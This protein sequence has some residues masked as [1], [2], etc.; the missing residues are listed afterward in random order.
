MSE[1]REL[2][3]SSIESILDNFGENYWRKL[4]EDGKYPEEFVEEFERKGFSSLLIPKEY[5]GLG[6]G[7]GEASI[8]L[9]EINAYGGNS[10]PFHGLY[11][12][13]FLVS[14]FASRE[15]KENYLPEIAKGKKRLQSFALTEPEAGSD[16]T[17]IKTFAKREG[18]NYVI[19]G[20][21]IFISRLEQTDL[22]VL[23]ART[24]PYEKVE[25]KTDGITLFLID[26][27]KSKGIKFNRI[28]TMFN[29]QTYE[30]FIED[31][32][33]GKESVIGDEGKGF[34]YLLYVL[35]PERILIAS[36]CIGDARWFINKAAEYSKNRI[37]FGR[38]I[39]SNQGIQFPVADA[40]ARLVASDSVRWKA[41]EIFERVEKG[42]GEMKEL[43]KYSNISKYLACECSWQAANIAMDVFGGYGMVKD[44]H[45]ER[46]FREN[47]LYRV[48]PIS[49]NLIL[50]FIAHNILGMPRSY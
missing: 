41:V 15:M 33:V 42:K 18:D 9:E 37:V 21:K 2:I 29:S 7:I 25:R 10:Q 39:G 43:G 4:D 23:A 13:S 34:S 32:Y 26:V 31:L 22:M 16:S 24:T 3:K 48:A 28:K 20:H 30:V 11:Y 6:L 1:E 49:N 50:S 47:R 17:R 12:L 35:N 45:I 36:E 40:Y 14:K 27:K 5:E 46:K 44:V 8:V 19:N 38:P